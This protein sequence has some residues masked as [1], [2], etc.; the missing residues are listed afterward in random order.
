MIFKSCGLWVPPIF[1]KYA[2]A[3]LLSTWSWMVKFDK[4]FLKVGL[5]ILMPVV[6]QHLF[7]N[8]YLPLTISPVETPLQYGP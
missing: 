2:R 5:Q 1:K 8:A 3:T 7:E 4:F 6:L